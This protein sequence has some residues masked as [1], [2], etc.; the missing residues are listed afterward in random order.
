ML[1]RYYLS[2]DVVVIEGV[3]IVVFLQNELTLFRK[4][5]LSGLVAGGIAQF[6]ASPTDLV[7]IHMQM[8]GRLRLEGHPPRYGI[9]IPTVLCSMLQDGCT[10]TPRGGRIIKFSSQV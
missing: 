9:N 3:W 7:K 5:L 6:V 8:E 1:R 2:V 10:A 4:A